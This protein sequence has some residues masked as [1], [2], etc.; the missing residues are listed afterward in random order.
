MTVKLYRCHRLWVKIGARPCWRVQR[1]LDAAGVDYEIVPGPR[2]SAQRDVLE[3]LSGQ[4]LYPVI[5]DTDGSVYR[6]ESK[7]MAEQIRTGHLFGALH[8]HDDEAHAIDTESM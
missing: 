2:N 8:G 4:R 5:V 6:A 3:E 1:E 7:E